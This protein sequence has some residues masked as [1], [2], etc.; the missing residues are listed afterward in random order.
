MAGRAAFVKHHVLATPSASASAEVRS[1]G[2]RAY[3]LTRYKSGSLSAKSVCDIA[4]YSRL[5]G[6]AGVDDLAYD[7]STAG[8]HQAEFL[9]NLF[10]RIADCAFYRTRVP[11]WNQTEQI[12]EF[13]DFPMSLPHERF[14]QEFEKNPADFCVS[15]FRNT[16]LPPFFKEHVVTRAKGCLK[17]TPIGYF[18]D[19]VPHT[20]KD[21]G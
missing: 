16:E 20:K 9:R 19:G 10:L 12:R 18:S 14:A 1:D 17:T 15:N 13:H 3:L 2:L 21:S 11:L 5:A 8:E 6:A 7:P 4:W